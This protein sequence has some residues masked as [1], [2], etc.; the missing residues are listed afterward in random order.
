MSVQS[1]PDIKN[2]FVIHY[3]GALH[4]VEANTFANSLVAIARVF[5]ETNCILFPDLK[6]EMRVEALAQGSFRPR[7]RL[8]TSSLLSHIT[9]FLPEKNQLIFV[10]LGILS[11]HQ[12]TGDNPASITINSDTVVFSNEKGKLEIPRT[13]YDSAKKLSDNKTIKAAIEQN[14]SIIASD[15]SITSFGFTQETD[16]EDFLFYETQTNFN[17]Y[18][19]QEQ[20]EEDEDR[21]VVE[22]DAELKLLK[23]ILEK[24]SRKWEFVWNGFKISAPVTADKF[25]E[26]LRLRKIQIAQG[27][28]IQAVLKI[29]QVRDPYSGAFLNERYE[30]SDV[31]EYC[32]VL[33]QRDDL[34]DKP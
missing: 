7:I 27:D 11:L 10:V 1:V 13:A 33:R 17:R 9:P 20:K 21:R 19:S 30:V 24:G 15:P 32:K 16:S 6:I 25:W 3:G 29:Y 5:E 4:S 14:F 26:D 28:S 31:K 12:C 8:F 2:G 23:V 22:Q 18:V 34:F